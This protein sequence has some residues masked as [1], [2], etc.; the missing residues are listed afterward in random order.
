MMLAGTFIQGV[1]SEL[2]KK[3]TDISVGAIAVYIV[4][5]VIKI[6]G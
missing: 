6:C 4:C 1:V 3:Q 5:L 2:L